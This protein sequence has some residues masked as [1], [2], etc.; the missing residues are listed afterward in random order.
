MLAE[1]DDF[2]GN[3]LFGIHLVRFYNTHWD[4]NASAIIISVND[5][6]KITPILENSISQQLYGQ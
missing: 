2:G 1:M 3:G 5:L 6:M 4:W